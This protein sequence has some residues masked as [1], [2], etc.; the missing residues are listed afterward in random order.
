MGV[1]K[2]VDVVDFIGVLCHRSGFI[3]NMHSTACR[4]RGVGDHIF[5]VD[6]GGSAFDFS[7][8]RGQMALRFDFGD[9]FEQSRPD[10][11]FGQ[12]RVLVADRTKADL[13]PDVF[14]PPGL[15]DDFVQFRAVGEELAQLFERFGEFVAGDL[16]ADLRKEDLSVHT[17][18][19]QW[20]DWA[21][22]KILP[23]NPTPDPSPEG[24]G[25]VAYTVTRTKFSLKYSFSG[26]YEPCFPNGLRWVFS[27]QRNAKSF[28]L[29]WVKT[30]GAAT[31]FTFKHSNFISTFGV[32]CS[33][34]D[35]KMPN[36]QY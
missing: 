17:L 5:T 12:S 35:I 33:V 32:R 34:F 26:V 3:P 24:R 31:T 21:N 7:A 8:D 2:V 25:A 6:D 29:R 13:P 19:F 30:P 15:V 28:P 14:K 10:L 36:T 11:V 16:F 4:N 18:Y 20:S 9:E 23:Y 22:V 1:I 27:S